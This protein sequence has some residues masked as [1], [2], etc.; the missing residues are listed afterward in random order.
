MA[1]VL[2]NFCYVHFCRNNNRH[3]YWPLFRSSSIG[4]AWCPFYNELKLLFLYMTYP[5]S[6]S[7]LTYVYKNIISPFLKK[8]EKDIDS[9]INN[10]KRGG[11]QTL[12]ATGKKFTN[13]LL[14]FVIK[15]FQLYGMQVVTLQNI[16][17]MVENSEPDG[18]INWEEV[19]NDSE[20]DIS[21]SESLVREG[22]PTYSFSD[23]YNSNETNDNKVTYDPPAS[24]TRRRRKKP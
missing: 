23:M 13:I 14:N 22:S 15:G 17:T 24:N 7:S 2:D 12:M 18:E 10:F 9:Q 4:L 16:N 19:I 8:H 21:S 1:N 6:D 3:I 5:T 11:L 20:D